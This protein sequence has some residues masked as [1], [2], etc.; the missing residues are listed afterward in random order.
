MLIWSFVVNVAL[1]YN[2]A[3][4]LAAS[5]SFGGGRTIPASLV[6]YPATIAAQYIIENYVYKKRQNRKKVS[7]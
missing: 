6:L 1:N 4:L 3:R 5:W 7:L 2:H